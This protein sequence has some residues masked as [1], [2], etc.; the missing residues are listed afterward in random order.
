MFIGARDSFWEC[1]ENWRTSDNKVPKTAP[2]GADKAIFPEV[3]GRGR[4]GGG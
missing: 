1:P 4:E 3:R 2:C